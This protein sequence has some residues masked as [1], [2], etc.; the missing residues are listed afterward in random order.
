MANVTPDDEFRQPLILIRKGKE[1][2]K[3][4]S[5]TLSLSLSPSLS[6]LHQ[7]DYISDHTE[8][9]KARE[10]GLS[11]IHLR[12]PNTRHPYTLSSPHHHLLHLPP[13]KG[14]KH[15]TPL[16]TL[17]PTPPF[18]PTS[19][20]SF[21]YPHLRAPKHKT[22]THSPPHTTVLSHFHHLLHLP[23]N[24][25]SL[26]LPKPSISPFSTITF[27]MHVHNSTTRT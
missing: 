22:L 1:W 13:P 6:Y 5:L 16:H 10:N 11:Q 9:V 23:P 8:N 27:Y 4:L 12:A 19:T 3:D 21:T 24:R 20:I 14:T 15:K 7:V 2:V 25:H 17:L 26:P 18:F